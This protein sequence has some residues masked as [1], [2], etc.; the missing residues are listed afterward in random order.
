MRK[1]IGEFLAGLRAGKGLTQREVAEKLCISDRTLSSWETDKRYPDILLLPAL[2]EL[3][4]VTTDEI[5]RGERAGGAEQ[6]LVKRP[7]EKGGERLRVRLAKFTVRA[8]IVC[9]VFAALAFVLFLCA[10][11]FDTV[12]A[13][14]IF[15][16]AL[17]SLIVCIGLYVAFYLGARGIADGQ[18]FPAYFYR[19]TNVLK[20]SLFALAGWLFFLGVFSL[21]LS[22][23]GQMQLFFAFMLAFFSAS[24]VMLVVGL[25]AYYHALKKYGKEAGGRACSRDG[26]LIRNTVLFGMIPLAVAV[27]CMITFNIWFPTETKELFRGSEEEFTAYNERVTVP[28]NSYPAKAGMPVGEYDLPIAERLRESGE[29]VG[30]GK[31]VTLDLGGG[32]RCVIDY[33]GETCAVYYNQKQILSQ[34]P[35]IRTEDGPDFY[36]LREAWERKFVLGDENIPA[37]A[38]KVERTRSYRCEGGAIVVTDTVVRYGNGLA[39]SLG[40]A[41]IIADVIVCFAVYAVKKTK[42]EI[43]FP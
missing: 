23:Y 1:S 32:L 5:L 14:V 21:V 30:G 20:N 41:V 26:R 34:I 16:V 8:G 19:L 37:G 22:C 27:A 25:A 15:F 6:P 42:V 4:G 17:A 31:L 29:S 43:V 11:W 13:T 36:A 9:T 24:A 28:E 40:T 3:Y 38:I 2:A 18:R 10:F 33:N 7:A 12:W 39:M 35:R